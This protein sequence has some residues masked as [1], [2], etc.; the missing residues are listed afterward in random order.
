MEK[1][2]QWL[3]KRPLPI[4]VRYGCATV[5]V[6]VCFAIMR[7]V[8]AES[9]ISSFF[10][11]YPA[12]FLAALLFDRG[13]GI[14]ATVL[15]TALLVASIRYADGPI[16]LFEPYWLPLALFFLVGIGLA[17]LTELLRIGWERAV[18]AEQAKDVLYR[19]LSHRTKNDFAMAAS[20]L[21]LQA[22]SQSSPEIRDALLTAGNRL[23]VL[24]KA[25]EQLEP[26][27]KGESVSMPDYIEALCQA[28]SESMSDVGHVSLWV[29]C[30]HLELPVR[31]AIP[32]GLIVN[33]LVTNA[34][35]HA[36][37]TASEGAMVVSLRRSDGCT[38]IVQDNGRGCPN[39]ALPGVG[40]QLVQLLVR[41]LNGDMERS[42][43]EPGCRV[44]V[45]FP[46]AD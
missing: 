36:F 28:L 37:A 16:A 6:A 8:E 46:E 14:Y 19:E 4:L 1:L 33:E 9:G 20:V 27:S 45:T 30:D 12:I 42:H 35:K 3:P 44:R 29:D 13:S 25:H 15:S 41:Q 32:V 40:S 38:L 7:W 5:M 39:D 22:R 43:A 21:G 2:L 24:G 34:Y 26:M 18:E 23:Q 11:L 10:L 17:A 31:R